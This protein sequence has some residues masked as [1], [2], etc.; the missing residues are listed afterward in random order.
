[1]WRK[2]KLISFAVPFFLCLPFTLAAQTYDEL[3]GQAVA[4]IGK[5]SLHRAEALLLEALKLEPMNSKNALL[6]SNLAGCN[7]VWA[8]PIKRWSLIRSR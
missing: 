5:D 6:F 4:C 7:A 3:S 2:Y 1:M 8:S